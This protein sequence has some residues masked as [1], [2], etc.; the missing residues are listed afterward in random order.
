MREF[1][2]NQHEIPRDKWRYGF[3]SSA[4]TGCGWIATY[5]A[6]K[7]LGCD[8][9]PSELIR[10]YSRKMPFYNGLFGTFISN[11]SGF[12]RKSGFEVQT[13]LR[14]D[15]FSKTVR[16]SEVCILY[17]C[18]REK[19]KFG[20]HYIALHQKNDTIIAY[21]VFRNSCGPDVLGSDLPE[22]ME[23]QHYFLPVLFGIKRKCE[24]L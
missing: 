4:A 17:Y 21:N 22:F 7:L 1:I 23:K 18:W 19:W 2:Y 12:F 16:E 3:R 14:R 9:D 8:P 10:Y 20:A 24:T 5:N 11:P 6:L 13:C 15:S